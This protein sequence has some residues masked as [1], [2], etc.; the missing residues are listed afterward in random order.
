MF[1]VVSRTLVGCG[2]LTGVQ[3][4]HRHTGLLRMASTATTWISGPFN[5]VQGQ[6]SDPADPSPGSF[7]N[8]S[9]RTGR[10]LS[11]VPRSGQLEINR[12]VAAARSAFPAWSALSGQWG[13]LGISREV[14]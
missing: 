8:I 3:T 2:Q 10:L 9:P 7:D 6:R 1:V 4:G 13:L 5:W 12:A 11:Q 14:M